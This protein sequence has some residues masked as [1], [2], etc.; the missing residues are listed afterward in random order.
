MRNAG[1]FGTSAGWPVICSFPVLGRPRWPT[2]ATALAC[3]DP[4]RRPP[5]ACEEARGRRPPRLH[6]YYRGKIQT[7][8]KAPIRSLADFAVWYTPGV[9]APCRAIHER[10]AL[11]YEHTNKANTVAVVSDGTRVLGLG[12]RDD[13]ARVDTRHGTA[14]AQEQGVARLARSREDLTRT[15][16][17]TIREAKTT[18]RVLM[19]AGVIR[20]MPGEDT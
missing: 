13:S 10:P 11:V 20:R 19:E 12:A 4:V 17:A 2:S 16:E 1:C 5:G 14:K 6:P 3:D 9:A 7:A 15:A 18:T 8:P